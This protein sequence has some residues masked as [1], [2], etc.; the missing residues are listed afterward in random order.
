MSKCLN[1]QTENEPTS[2]F[3]IGCGQP[4]TAPTAAPASNNPV[5][6][7]PAPGPQAAP[8]TAPAQPVAPQPTPAV[9]PAQP[10]QPVAGAG[11]V[12]MSVGGGHN[13]NLFAFL[14]AGFIKPKQTVE[15]E[16]NNV[17][18]FKTAGLLAVI[19]V[20]GAHVIG[21]LV[22][23]VTMFIEYEGENKFDAFKTL[24]ET[25]GALVD[26]LTQS[27]IKAPLFNLVSLFAVAGIFMI[28]AMIFKKQ[29]FNYNKA[30]SILSLALLPYILGLVL[31]P[32]FT[33]IYSPLGF[34]LG[35]IGYIYGLIIVYELI[36][37]ML[38]FDTKKV[39]YNLVAFA[40]IFAIGKQA[41]NRISFE[42]KILPRPVIS[43]S[44]SS[45]INVENLKNTIESLF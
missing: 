27:L 4:L 43:S 15:E 45:E 10:A 44:A 23:L 29:D 16:T 14:V 2:K 19:T 6:A 20:F 17:S 40:M 12:A 21:L 37:E 8:Q 24:T 5:A 34:A 39:L 42:M 36:N 9:P 26:L 18:S 7:N 38:K 13:L 1:C 30:V 41:Y 33:K 35:K 28:V 31:V 11:P 22:Y 25:E 32:I 3:C